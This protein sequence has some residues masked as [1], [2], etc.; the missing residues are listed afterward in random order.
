M[1]RERLRWLA[2]L[3]GV[4]AGVLPPLRYQL[5]HRIAATLFEADRYGSDKALLLVHSFSTRLTGFP[6][7]TAFLAALG[8][9]E[10]PTAGQIVGPIRISGIDFYAGWVADLP[11]RS[12]GTPY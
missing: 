3:L 12:L 2:D 6:D 5:F 7:F 10:A 1:Q 11:P 9:E 8:F 4:R